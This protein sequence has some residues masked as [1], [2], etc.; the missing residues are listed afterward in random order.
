MNLESEKSECEV[1]KKKCHALV[2]QLK[3]R[4]LHEK[5]VLT[6][7]LYEPSGFMTG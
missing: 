5:L 2:E 1:Q 7:L 4:H 3:V 6:R